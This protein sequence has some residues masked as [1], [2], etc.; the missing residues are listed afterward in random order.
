MQRLILSI[1][2]ISSSGSMVYSQPKPPVSPPVTPV[3]VVKPKGELGL[4]VTP[5]EITSNGIQIRGCQI[6]SIKPNSS[7]AKSRLEV[8]DVI[9]KAND[10]DVKTPEDILG[11]IEASTTGKINITVID[12]RTGRT[13]DI[14][15]VEAK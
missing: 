14:G 3:P 8:G 15:D 6:V 10:K 4:I 13:I 11:V 7:A 2:L 5:I 12:K 1:I 9:I